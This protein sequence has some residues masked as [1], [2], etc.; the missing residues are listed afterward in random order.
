MSP[1]KEFIYHLFSYLRENAKFAYHYNNYAY[2]KGCGQI[3]GALRAPY[4][5]FQH[6]LLAISVFA[7]G[8][9]ACT[10]IK[11]CACPLKSIIELYRKRY[12]KSLCKNLELSIIIRNQ[13]CHQ[14][15][16]Q[17]SEIYNKPVKGNSP[18]SGYVAT[19]SSWDDLPTQQKF[20]IPF[21][22]SNL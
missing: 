20:L 21:I 2:K 14:N 16:M 18:T 15:R 8:N 1:V 17:I 6:P 5:H 3:F 4:F 7:P 12:T 13:I 10:Y 9:S 11:V 19:D 22:Y